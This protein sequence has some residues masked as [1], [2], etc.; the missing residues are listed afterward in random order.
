MT[1][2]VLKRL[3]ALIP[4]LLTLSV[5]A[6]LLVRALPGDP[7]IAILGPNASPQA[8]SHLRETLGL[9]RPLLEQY[10]DYL[11]GLLR[12]DLGTSAVSQQPIAGEI[13]NRA[14]ATI[15]LAAAAILIGAPLG[16]LAGRAAARRPGTVFDTASTTA[17]IVTISIPAF[18]LGLILQYLFAVRLQWLPAIG[19]RT[20]T[21]LGA[22]AGGFLL[23]PSLL[24]GQLSIFL[25]ALRHLV[26]PA[27]T[28]AAVPVA[29]VARVTRSAYLTQSTRPHVRIAQAK[30]LTPRK[31]RA[32][33]IERNALPPIVV[34]IGLQFGALLAG[35]IITENIFGWGGLGA[36]IVSAIRTRDYL[37]IQSAL[38]VLA[39]IYVLVNL[40]VD[41]VNA[42]LDPRLRST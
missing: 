21:G 13:L 17:T 30:G 2:F 5:L 12:G 4:M 14:P 20:D 28:L 32:R 24:S 39:L 10:G 3:L 7:A 34:V 42:R 11:L 27:L 8:V 33:H 40:A 29:V 9:E 35:S 31:V 1:V 15:E 38:L 41:V 37:V 26:L 23:L 18:V 36:L 19:R 22:D 25:D 16:A 6:F